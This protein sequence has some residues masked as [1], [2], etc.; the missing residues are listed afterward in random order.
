MTVISVPK[1]DTTK[2]LLLGVAGMVI[3]PILFSTSAMYLARR[4]MRNS[5][6][7]AS[8]AFHLGLAGVIFGAYI[9]VRYV[10]FQLQ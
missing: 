3:M 2:A 7:G 5:E 10:Q 8:L 6:R 4:G 1:R 9:F